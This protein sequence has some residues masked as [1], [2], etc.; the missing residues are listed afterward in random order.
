MPQLEK[1]WNTLRALK[2]HRHRTVYFS[3]K[4]LFSTQAGFDP[5]D[6][7]AGEMFD[8]MAGGGEC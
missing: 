4:Q 3:F 8:V 7:K 1:L 5:Q 2:S 6:K